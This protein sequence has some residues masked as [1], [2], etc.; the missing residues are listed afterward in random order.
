MQGWLFIDTVAIVLQVN[1]RLSC[2]RAFHIFER[3]T[4]VLLYVRNP[5]RGTDWMSCSPVL[6]FTGV[7]VSPELLKATVVPLLSPHKTIRCSVQVCFSIRYGVP[8]TY[9]DADA[10]GRRKRVTHAR[11]ARAAPLDARAGYHGAAQS[12]ACRACCAP[13]PR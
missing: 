12:Q 10:I 9:G 3:S 1:S 11:S 4:R 5:R 13:W 7:P 2:L 6:D 8:R